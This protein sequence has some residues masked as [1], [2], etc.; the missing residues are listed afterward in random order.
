MAYVFEDVPTI[1]EWSATCQRWRRPGVPSRPIS[2]L[3]SDELANKVVCVYTR[4]FNRQERDVG[5]VK[6]VGAS[7]PVPG[8]YFWVSGINSIC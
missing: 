2:A 6:P 7:T 8:Q 1:H 3:R 5:L 4:N